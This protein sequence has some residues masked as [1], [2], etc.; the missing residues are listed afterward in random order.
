MLE[1]V[2]RISEVELDTPQEKNANRMIPYTGV[3]DWGPRDVYV[4]IIRGETP[5]Y[6]IEGWVL[7]VAFNPGIC[8][9]TY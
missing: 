1:A 6:P 2:K 7:S 5:E 9:I 4:Q 3:M 8:G